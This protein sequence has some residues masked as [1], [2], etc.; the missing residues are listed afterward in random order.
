MQVNLNQDHLITVGIFVVYSQTLTSSI[1]Q[2]NYLHY[3]RDF[4]QH[5]QYN[6]FHFV[7]RKG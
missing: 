4:P 5:C 6:L 2:F 1:R 3:I 7:V